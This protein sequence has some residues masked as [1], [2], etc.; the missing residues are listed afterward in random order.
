QTSALPISYLAH[1]RHDLRVVLS[2]RAFADLQHVLDV[3]LRDERLSSVREAVRELLQDRLLPLVKQTVRSM[4]DQQRP[5]QI[6]DRFLVTIACGERKAEALKRHQR[7]PA[8][9]SLR[10]LHDRERFFE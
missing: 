8:R 4:R 1:E 6:G 7:V 2:V 10:A 5:V 9:S 3:S